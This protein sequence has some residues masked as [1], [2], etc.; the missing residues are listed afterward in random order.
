M[1]QAK[2]TSKGQI[3]VPI[4]VRRALGLSVG[5]RVDFIQLPSGAYEFVPASGTVQ[6]VRGLIRAPDRPVTL[7]EMDAAIAAGAAGVGPT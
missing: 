3:T 6:S 1:P 4:E 5:S 7:Q 2:L